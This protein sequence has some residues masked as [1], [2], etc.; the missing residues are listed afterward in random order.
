MMTQFLFHVNIYV[1]FCDHLQ[2]WKRVWILEA[3]SENGCGKWHFF[4]SELRSGFLEPGGTTP[5][6]ISR[7]T[8]RGFSFMVRESKKQSRAKA[9]QMSNEKTVGEGVKGKSQR[10]R[11]IFLLRLSPLPFPIVF[12][13]DHLLYETRTQSHPKIRLPRRLVTLRSLICNHL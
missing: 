9:K 13:F 7:S 2:V 10:G 4:L 11:S 3:R 6:S 1:A 12:S 5:A 8:S